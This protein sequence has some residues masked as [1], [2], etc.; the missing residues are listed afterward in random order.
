[1]ASCTTVGATYLFCQICDLAMAREVTH[2]VWQLTR[3]LLIASKNLQQG[4]AALLL[5]SAVILGG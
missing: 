3:G 2:S 5:P 1:M 4:R